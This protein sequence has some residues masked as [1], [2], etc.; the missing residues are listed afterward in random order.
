MTKEPE[1]EIKEYPKDG[2][3]TTY[4]KELLVLMKAEDN[5][6]IIAF[7]E[8]VFSDCIE[9]LKTAFNL[10]FPNL[11]LNLVNHRAFSE[12]ADR[13]DKKF[14]KIPR[15]RAMIVGIANSAPYIY[16][17]FQSHFEGYKPIEFIANLCVSYIEELIHASDPTKTETQIQEIVCSAIE[18]F[19]EIKLPDSL[20]Q[21]RLSYAKTCDDIQS[22]K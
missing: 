11:F 7:S 8:R 2:R 15:H 21:Y 4:E 10:S 5:D 9:Y 14:G 16:I 19:L 12:L 18:G 17:D 20:K 6:G 1:F 3:L 13:L 22:K